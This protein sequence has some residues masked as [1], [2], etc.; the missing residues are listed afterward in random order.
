MFFKA[1]KV[2][3]IHTFL[4]PR[5]P[6]KV[7]MGMLMAMCFTLIIKDGSAQDSQSLKE[8]F[9]IALDDTIRL[10]TLSIAPSTFEIR[11]NRALVAD[12]LYHFLPAKA[13]LVPR[14]GFPQDSVNIKYRTLSIDLTK[15]YSRRSTSIIR[16]GEDYYNDPYTFRPETNTR[17]VFGS[18]RLNKTGSI[19]RGLGFGNNQDLTVNSTLSLQLSGKITDD[20]SVLAS[21]T[22][23][24]IPIQPEGNTAQLQEFDQ[25]YI[26]LYDAKSSLTAG[27]FI[28]RR[29]IGY[30]STYFKRAQGASF[31]TRQKLGAGKYTLFTQTSAALSRGKFARNI[32]QGSEGNQGPYRLRGN[33]NE[34]F[35]IVLAGTERVFIDG[36]EMQRGQ[37]ND[38]IIDYNTAEITFTAKQLINKDKRIAVE[39]QYT[40]ANYTRSLIQTSTGIESEKARFYVNFYSEQ[41]AK[42]QPLQQDLTDDD[43]RILDAAGDDLGSANAPGFTAVSEFSND[44]ILYTLVD[45]LGYDSIFVRVNQE[46]SPLF[47]VNFSEVGQGNGDYIQEGFDASGRIFLWVAPDTVGG[48]IVRNGEYA[49]IR[50]LVAPQKNQLLMV[51]AEL[52]PTAKTNAM[53]EVGFSNDDLNTF[54]DLGNDDNFSM[55]LMAKLEHSQSLSQ[56]PNAV[57]LVGSVMVESRGENFQPIEPYRSVEFRRNWNLNDSLE[58]N[59]QTIATGGL[60]LRKKNQFDIQYSLDRFDAGSEYRALKNNLNADWDLDGLKGWFIGSILTTEGAIKSRFTRHKAMI[61]KDLWVTTIGFTDERED[62]NQFM[63]GTDSLS[64]EAYRFYDWQFYLTDMDSSSL[65]YRIFYRERTD[66]AS[67]LNDYSESTHAIHYGAELGLL[68]NP[69]NTIKALISNRVLEIS[70]P[71]LTEQEPE[72]TLLL[73]LEHAGRF[74]KNTVVTNTYYEIGSGL[75][76]RQEFIYILDPTGQGPYTWI[77]YNNNGIKEL[78][79]FELARPEDGERYI[80]VFTP[81]DTYERAYSNQFSQ[82]LNLNPAGIWT[83]QEG[84]KKILSKFSNQ[85]AFRIQRKTRQEDGVNRF[86]PFAESIGDEDLISQS[87][88]IRNTFFFN[89]TSSKF[90]ADFT[91]SN[92][93]SKNPL[94]TGFEERENRAQIW[95]LRY[96]ITS[97]YGIILEQEF[98]RRV[99]A[100]DIIDGRNFDIDYLRLKP[101]FSYQ[102]STEFRVN[103]SGAFSQKEND[104]LLGGETAELVDFGADIRMSKIEKGTYFG[105]INLINIDYSG[106]TN[107]SLAYEML[108]GLQNGRNIT[109]SAGVQRNLGKNL[110]LSLSYNGRKSEEVRSIHT[111]NV[112]VR[113]FF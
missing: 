104:P 35:I 79:E 91:Y 12:S 81:T 60:G 16:E 107:N 84:I 58:S 32:L 110:Q 30:F 25:V 89:R 113:A 24:N 65:D 66:F 14:A 50:R 82:T 47:T 96:N 72:R 21:V 23:D 70:D 83:N 108:D 36:Q 52:K 98:G 49:P 11:Q 106:V 41:D 39:F 78:N 94:T 103:L 8:K 101:T 27:D 33:E 88:S 100:S 57:E 22:D 63:P 29:P 28:I 44:R 87:S 61:E 43:R 85:T 105:T 17:T 1:P 10:D 93:T 31:E 92:L 75:E 51:G 55:A 26:K 77:D 111:G 42:N 71:E 34:T 9:F 73:R 95:R 69:R 99:S 90:G 6:K 4:I 74:L 53:V 59:P 86:N 64:N 112:Q 38:Y 68:G 15:Q 109:W 45:S 18:T 13:I 48:Q 20:I 76:R 46:T 5:R 67:A 40:D 97:E 37:Q 7:V 3:R 102:P 19:S 2:K 80:R 54:S 62:N 56:K